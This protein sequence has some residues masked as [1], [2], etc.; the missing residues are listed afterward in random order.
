MTEAYNF[1]K[2]GQIMVGSLSMREEFKVYWEKRKKAVDRTLDKILPPEDRFPEVLHRAM[3]Y[4]LFAGGKRL[5][6]ILAIMGYEIAM[7]SVNFEPILPIA[8]A[9]ELVH[10]FSL[11]HDDLPAMD[12][13]DMRRG[14]PSCHKVFGEG[15]AILAGDALFALAFDIIAS[16]DVSPDVKARVF[17]ELSQATGPNG[18]AGG[19]VLDLV[20]E[21][22]VPTKELVLEI[23][24]RKTAALI[25]CSLV[26]GGIVGGASEKLLGVFGEVGEKLG[27]AFQI[28]DDVLDEIGE[29]EKMGKRV[30]KDI[31]RGKCTYVRVRGVQ[32][33]LEDA[34]KLVEEVK[35]T[36]EREIGLDKG[37]ALLELSD[38]IVE[39]VS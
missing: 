12:D 36:I 3:R 29:K 8:C 30:K 25:R 21:G 18:L 27:I 35:G 23:H 33:S 17:K 14:K 6:P 13:D 7:N 32:G 16:A 28:V 9:I 20:S 24:K 2:I 31:A 34:R 1:L 38:F 37:W 5:R 26:T 39:R 19:Q 10:T 4:T 11:I 22:A 15:L